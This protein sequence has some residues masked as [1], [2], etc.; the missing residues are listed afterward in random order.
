MHIPHNDARLTSAADRLAGLELA[1]NSIVQITDEGQPMPGL[2]AAMMAVHQQR[3][4]LTLEVQ[5]IA[6]PILASAGVDLA[7]FAV[8][9]VTRGELILSERAPAPVQ[10]VVESD[11]ATA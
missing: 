11:A 3:L 9:Q 7:A 1:L 8:T 6:I 10:Q 2:R 4:T 5:N